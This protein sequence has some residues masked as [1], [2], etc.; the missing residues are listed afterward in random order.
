MPQNYWFLPFAAALQKPGGVVL[1]GVISR[2][3]PVVLKRLE[4]IAFPQDGNLF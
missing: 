4:Q 1:S 2:T 3:K